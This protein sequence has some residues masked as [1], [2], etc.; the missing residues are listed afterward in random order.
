MIGIYRIINKLNN[1]S[2]IGQSINIE[3][4]W[5][6]HKRNL[7][8]GEYGWYYEARQES[9][10]LDDF[11][12]E[13]VEEREVG[14]LDKKE[15]E[16]ISVFDSFNS[17]YNQ[18]LGNIKE[19]YHRKEKEKKQRTNEEICFGLINI[20]LNNKL[21]TNGK[22]LSSL[23]LIEQ[24][25]FLL[26]IA[27]IKRFDKSSSLYSISFK[28]YEKAFGVKV[29]SGC[30]YN[31]LKQALL[32]LEKKRYIDIAGKDKDRIVV[33]F[34]QDLRPFLFH[35]KYNYT[36]FSCNEVANFHS[37]YSLPLFLLLK[38]YSQKKR[39]KTF[40]IEELREKLSIEPNKYKRFSS[41]NQQILER[42]MNEIDTYTDLCV[43]YKL[44][45]R[46]SRAYTHITFYM[47]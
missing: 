3:K 7:N 23:S 4:R 9:K 12:F 19:R 40:S 47:D 44:E 30:M 13:V 11:T 17:G 29:D 37:S 36:C 1:K 35:Q 10:S 39:E 20:I 26:L 16:Y 24:R 45:K 38:A 15:I 6:Q 18:T 32:D 27:K 5:Q 21:I 42:A 2:Y 14:E 28:E 22:V 46:N 31:T 41:F 34:C 25:L 43:E 33:L 8:K